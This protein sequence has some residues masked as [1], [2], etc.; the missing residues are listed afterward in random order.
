M[1]YIGRSLVA[2]KFAILGQGAKKMKKWVD[3]MRCMK[4]PSSYLGRSARC[5]TKLSCH[6]DRIHHRRSSHK[7]T[8]CASYYEILGEVERT[9]REQAVLGGRHNDYV[10]GIGG[11]ECHR[12][13][14]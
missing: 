6:R 7:E 9:T 13:H 2:F 1:G 5:P 4:D 8:R 11:G 3:K 12:M 10:F 14:K